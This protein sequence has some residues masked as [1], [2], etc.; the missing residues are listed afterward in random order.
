[1]IRNLQKIRDNSANPKFSILFQN[2]K[3]DKIEGVYI[4]ILEILRRLLY[5]INMI[6]L[7]PSPYIQVILNSSFSFAICY[8]ILLYKPYKTKL[9]NIMSFYTEFTT[10]LILSVIGAF[11]DEDLSRTLYDLADWSL[12]L[13]IILSIMIPAVVNLFV[14]IKNFLTWVR[15]RYI[16]SPTQKV[17]TFAT[18]VLTISTNKA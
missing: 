11:I 16:R 4:H 17:S 2:L 13:M 6:L 5:G 8:F 14:S 9:D 15:A 12:F 3:V 7:Y 1:L 10:F 18:R